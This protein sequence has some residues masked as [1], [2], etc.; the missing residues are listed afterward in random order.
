MRPP[1][2]PPE[3]HQRTLDLTTAAGERLAGGSMADAIAYLDNEEDVIDVFGSERSVTFRIAG[4]PPA[5]LVDHTG[6]A[7]TASVGDAA[8]RSRASEIRLA[9]V[10][11]DDTS[12]DGQVDNR[13]V[14]RALVLAPFMWQF[15]KGDESDHIAERLGTM[16]GYEDN[17]QLRANRTKGE[18]AITVTDWGSFDDFDAIFISTHGYR[19]CGLLPDGSRTCR[20]VVMTGINL[21]QFDAQVTGL[22][23]GFIQ[24]GVYD[25]ASNSTRLDFSLG[26]VADGFRMLYPDGLDDTLVSLSACETGLITG[27][28]LAAALA[29]AGNDFVM[30]AWTEPVPVDAAFAASGVLIEQLSLGLTSQQA[31]QAV[32]AAG[33]GSVVDDN[34]EVTSLEHIS[35]GDDEVRLIEVP[36]LL[37]GDQPMRDGASISSSVVGTP[38]DL[39][40][41]QLT[42]DLQLVGIDDP[43]RYTVRY[44]VDGDPTDGP[45]DL[46]FAREGDLPYTYDVRHEVD[47][48]FGVP[49]GEVEL[50]AIVDLPEGGE[51]RYSVKVEVGG[52]ITITI[53]GQTWVFEP[54]DQPGSC[55]VSEDGMLAG[56]GVDGRFDGVTFSAVLTPDGGSIDVIDDTMD[57]HWMANAERDAMTVFHLIPGGRS[58]V[59]EIAIENGRARGT[60]TFIETNEALMAWR[61]KRDWPASI[62]GIFDIQ[63]PV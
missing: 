13:D 21:D 4:A 56:G 57:E 18:Q 20:T 17:V 45:H 32:I 42:L 2:V 31:Y 60:A 41:D 62:G 53:G 35:P 36:T 61:E 44:E 59:D 40:S 39:V 8:R 5:W 15:G 33:L 63:C 14:K 55:L 48:G 24:V 19:E 12:G 49:M 54:F 6:V 26:A 16:P 11:G 37:S 22:Y 1:D 30:F 29:P 28:E 47:V 27:D 34:G 52:G 43:S 10:V 58:Q 51:S 38:G 46:F 9:S 50:T 25:R 23:R 3:L 7:A